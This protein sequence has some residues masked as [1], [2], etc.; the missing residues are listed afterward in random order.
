MS[1]AAW[2]E[3]VRPRR[4]GTCLVDRSSPF[5]DYSQ[6]LWRIVRS[7]AP[8]YRSQ[9]R[10]CDGGQYRINMQA[11]YLMVEA[12]LLFLAPK[13]ILDHS[14]NGT[15]LFEDLGQRFVHN[16]RH[17]FYHRSPKIDGSLS[18]GRKSRRYSTR[19][20]VCGDL[21]DMQPRSGSSGCQHGFG[22]VLW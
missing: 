19:Q 8:I 13:T 12:H 20:C 7:L 3:S 9:P 21:R 17:L 5:L 22:V 11:V 18:T 4:D 1:W 15:Y 16:G 10:K 6:G 14:P 2:I